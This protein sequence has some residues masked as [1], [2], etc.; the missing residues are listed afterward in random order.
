MKVFIETVIEKT[1]DAEVEKSFYLESDDMQFMIRKYNGKTSI[2]ADGKERDSFETIG[3]YPSIH[4]ALNH[5]LKMK[6]KESTATTL[7]ELSEDMKR[8][9]NMIKAKFEVE[10]QEGN[11]VAV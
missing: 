6:V 11:R 4:S 10:L 7:K 1:K 5:I 9:E 8:I 2:G 3:Y